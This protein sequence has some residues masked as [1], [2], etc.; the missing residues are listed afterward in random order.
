VKLPKSRGEC[1][2]CPPKS[3]SP[4]GPKIAELAHLTATPIAAID[5]LSIAADGRAVRI[6]RRSRTTWS[7]R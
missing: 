7:A 4:T 5:H 6:R 3:A 2:T 1:G